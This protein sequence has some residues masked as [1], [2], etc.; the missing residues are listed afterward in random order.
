MC[1]IIN[2]IL[3]F[4]QLQ[5]TKVQKGQGKKMGKKIYISA[6]HGVNGDPGAV[7]INGTRIEAN[8]TL[9]LSL[10]T[11]QELKNRGYT[12][13]MA[14]TVS[15]LTGNVDRA[16]D[17]NNWGADA[18]I[19]IHRNGSNDPTAH[20][21]EVY[22]RINPSK[23]S[24]ELAKAINKCTI[25]AGV[26]RVRDG[27]LKRYDFG[28]L[29][30]VKMAAVLTEHGFVNNV[31]DNELF[32]QKT[33]EYARA[34]GRAL[35]DI[36]GVQEPTLPPS[37]PPP[38]LPPE[39]FQPYTVRITVDAL[40]IRKGPGTDYVVV[41]VIRD[42]GVYTIVEESSGEG[43]TAWGRLKSGVGWIGLDFVSKL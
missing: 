12:T 28:R 37:P 35:D 27:G 41:G 13:R 33:S 3:Y 40:N 31:K 6:G 32:D 39:Q 38:P 21:W 20:G 17:A 43:A 26:Q 19:E 18:F 4:T 34:I 42:R 10:A 15:N 1:V 9:K 11:E 36:Y 23:A 8:D 29:L 22:T 14:R 30:S 25:E 7:G 2:K 16:G 24:D 5:R